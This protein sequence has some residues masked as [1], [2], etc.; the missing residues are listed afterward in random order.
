MT[1]AGRMRVFSQSVVIRN[2][3]ATLLTRTFG[4]IATIFVVANSFGQTIEDASALFARKQLDSALVIAKNII[5]H[6]KSDVNAY[7]LAGR[8]LVA[9]KNFTDAVGYLEK[10]QTFSDAPAYSKAWAMCELAS[11]YYSTGDYKKAKESLTGCIELNAT[12]NATSAAN[13][14]MLKL[15]LDKFYDTWTTKETPHFIFH[16][17]DTSSFSVSNFIEKKE[18]AFV[19]INKF[20]KAKLPKKIDYFVWSN[21]N[22]AESL[23]KRGLAFTDAALCITH[24]EPKHTVGH[25]MTHSISYYAVQNA[26]WNR[27]I[28][29]GVCVYFDLSKRDNIASLKT[30]NETPISITDIWK[31]DSKLG[32]EIIYPLGGELVKRLIETFGREKFMQ[33]LAD[34]SYESAKKIYGAEL[35]TTINK[36]AEEIKQ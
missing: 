26:K 35:D 7:V 1:M 18:V 32:E 30:K 2:A 10:A 27:L 22:L 14:L 33:L 9:K 12:K 6:D 16:F 20:F 36:L 29:E 28:A 8:I 17:Q 25:E 34:Q 3:M 5:E 15:G 11:C 21:S 13:F 4:T 24:T 23:F 19:S 31:S